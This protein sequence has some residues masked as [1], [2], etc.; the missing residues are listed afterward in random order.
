MPKLGEKHHNAKLSDEDVKEMRKLRES[1]PDLWSY[2]ALAE[3]FG[4]GCSTVR[5]LVQYRT[6]WRQ[7]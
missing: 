3:H 2:S 4:C 7:K 6:R 5:D 1:R